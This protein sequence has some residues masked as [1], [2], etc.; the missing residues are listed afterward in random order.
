[1]TNAGRRWTPVGSTSY[2]FADIPFQ[3]VLDD[4]YS[5]AWVTSYGIFPYATE[6]E[7]TGTANF[8]TPVFLGLTSPSLCGGVPVPLSY[9]EI[10]VIT[11]YPS[12]QLTG[13]SQQNESCFGDE[14]GSYT[15]SVSAANPAPY[16]ITWEGT[17][18]TD[19]SFDHLAPGEY[20][21]TVTD[22][23][24][25]TLV[26]TIT[27]S[28][29]ALL[30]QSDAVTPEVSGNDGTVVITATGGTPPY[31]YSVGGPSQS[32]NTFGNLAPGTYTSVVTDANGCTDSATFVIETLLSAGELA[33]AGV[34]FYPNPAD[35]TLHVEG[36][37]SGCVLTLTDVSGKVC[38][39]VVTGQ[40]AIDVSGLHAGIYLVRIEK[41]EVL[42]L[43]RQLIKR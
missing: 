22:G 28:G 9:A 18:T 10:S 4:S 37:E 12:V 30:Q 7:A 8:P 27:I 35:Q 13:V 1:M 32:S 34:S 2:S 26:D 33:G 42:L 14:D 16:T 17:V 3:F 11:Q 40:D 6:F 39:A 38:L 23:N 15:F 21:L 25:C 29:A 20:P 41:D 24:T 19:Q 31:S 5:L 43:S 36:V